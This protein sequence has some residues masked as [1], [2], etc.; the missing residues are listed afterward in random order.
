MID[1]AAVFRDAHSRYRRRRGTNEALT[2][3]ECLRRAW[4]AAKQRQS[5]VAMYHA[6]PRHIRADRPFP[7]AA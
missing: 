6:A 1:K 7:I 5:E 3:G 2:F 4:R